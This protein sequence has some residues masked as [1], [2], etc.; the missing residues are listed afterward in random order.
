M[1]LLRKTIID[2]IYIFLDNTSFG[3]DS[4]NINFPSDG[5]PLFEITFLAF[6]EYSFLL[7]EFKGE[8]KTYI[9]PGVYKT[10]DSNTYSDITRAISEILTWSARIREELTSQG[11][12]EEDQSEYF[13]QIDEYIESLKEPSKRFSD[14]EIEQLKKK[15]NDLEAKFED[16]YKKTIVTEQELNIL[17]SKTDGA[18]K[19][20]QFYSKEIWYKTAMRGIIG[21]SKRILSTKE[22]KQVAVEIFKKLIG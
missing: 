14:S 22:G 6:P 4:Y 8:I 18:K 20:L 19:D 10:Q 7:N 1:T 2:K 3:R 5:N 9:S 15:L 13:N 21:T 11:L 16:L 12:R 17:K